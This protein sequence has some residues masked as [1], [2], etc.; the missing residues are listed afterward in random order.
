MAGAIAQ[1]VVV[2]GLVQGVGFRYWTTYEASRIGVTGW[3]TNRGDGTVLAH[4]EGSQADVARLLDWFRSG[5]PVSAEVDA[6][7]VTDA[8]LEGS[9][10]FEIR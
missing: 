9:K 10:R 4:V 2:L 3:V 6:V 8:E 7:E 1:R 5:G